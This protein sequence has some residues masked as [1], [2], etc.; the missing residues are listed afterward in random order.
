MSCNL[1]SIP[2]HYCKPKWEF[3]I[4]INNVEINFRRL[5]IEL[6]HYIE[7]FGDYINGCYSP[8]N[9]HKRNVKKWIESEVKNGFM[10]N[11]DAAFIST[12]LDIGKDV[13]VE[14]K[15]HFERLQPIDFRYVVFIEGNEVYKRTVAKL[16]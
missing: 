11:R 4:K 9:R 15:P 6:D 16:Y 8:N 10:N 5:E 2:D 13:V 12:C 1:I 7:D 3:K 14:Q